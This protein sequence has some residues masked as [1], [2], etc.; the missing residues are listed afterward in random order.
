M[1]SSTASDATDLDSTSTSSSASPSDAI[2]TVEPTSMTMITSAWSMTTENHEDNQTFPPM[3]THWQ[4][5]QSC[6]WTYNVDG[7]LSASDSGAVAWLDLEPTAG[8]ST[9]SCYPDGMFF[10]G[11][12]GVFS[13]GTCPNGWTTVSLRVNTNEVRDEATTTAICC[14]SEYF[15]D[16]DQC[17]RTIP[18]VLA[19]PITYNHTART[20]DIL[21]DSTTTLYSATIAVYTIR[22]LFQE[23][24]KDNLGLKDEDDIGTEEDPKGLPLGARIGI[25]IGVAV[26][27]LLAIAG[28]AMF[29][30]RRDRVRARKKRSHELNTMSRGGQNGDNDLHAVGEMHERRDRCGDHQE[31]FPL[32]DPTTT[33]TAS[34]MESRLSGDTAT[35]DDEIKA[36]RD[37]KE[38]IQRRIEHLEQSESSQNQD[39]DEERN[40]DQTRA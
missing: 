26:F 7:N 5:P 30:I 22:A 17:K 10:Q 2:F 36:L 25:G 8:A 4:V 40:P 34:I 18:T 35:R 31:P 33:D 24:D 20:Y 14:S 38:A 37:Q 32:Y 28:G 39:Q 12:T 11:R 23:A 6:T 9:L 16:G 27:V 3:T 21:S 13:P 15:L 29:I 19:V 1:A